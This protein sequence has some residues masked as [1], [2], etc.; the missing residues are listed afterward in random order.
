MYCQQLNWLR[1]ELLV[2]HPVLIDRKGTVLQHHNTRP[3]AARLTQKIRQLNWEVFLILYSKKL[4][5]WFYHI[6]IFIVY[7]MKS[8]KYWG[9]LILVLRAMKCD[10]TKFLCMYYSLLNSR[11][12]YN[13]LSGSLTHLITNDSICLEDGDRVTYPNLHCIS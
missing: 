4:W 1:N 7:T 8:V 5:Q 3:H 6:Y 9:S 10:R 2:K 13:V 11:E 12:Y